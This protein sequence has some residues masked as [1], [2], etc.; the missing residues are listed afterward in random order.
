LQDFNQKRSGVR[1]LFF[2]VS[3][4]NGKLPRADWSFTTGITDP[5]SQELY[6][7]FNGFFMTGQCYP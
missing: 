5:I 7:C 1:T 2:N 6:D 4:P 3:G